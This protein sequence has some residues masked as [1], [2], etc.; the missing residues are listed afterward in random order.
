MMSLTCRILK[1]GTNE[2][3]EQKQ[4]HRHR[5]QTYDYQGEKERRDKLGDWGCLIHTNICKVHVQPL[6]LYPTLCNR[7][8]CRPARLLCPWGFSRQEY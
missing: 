5:K 4:S 7:V 2:P 6:Q 1:N 3:P 8:D